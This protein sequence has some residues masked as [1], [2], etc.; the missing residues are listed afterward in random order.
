MEDLLAVVTMVTMLYVVTDRLFGAL[1]RRSQKIGIWAGLAASCALA[2]IRSYT[3]LVTKTA[4]EWAFYGF[5]GTTFFGLL[6]LIFMLVRTRFFSHLAQGEKKGTLDI[7]CCVSGGAL[8]GF[9]IYNRCRSVL[10][11]PFIFETTGKGFFSGEYFLR[12]AGWA[13][14]LLLLLLYACL[15]AKCLRGYRKLHLPYA[16]T[17][18]GV[19]LMVI[20]N[21]GRS[22]G[23]W[24]SPRG[25][26]K[27][28][29]FPVKYSAKLHRSWAVP[30]YQFAENGNFLLT[31]ILVGLAVLLMAA[32]FIQNTRIVDPYDNPAQKRKLRARARGYR[33][34]TA[35]VVVCAAL[36]VVSMTAVKAYASQVPPPPTQGEYTVEDGKLYI[37]VEDVNDGSLH[38]FKYGNVRW[39]VIKK[40]NGNSYGVGLDA[41]DVCGVDK[42]STYFQRG[43]QVVCRRCDVVMNVNTIGIYGGCN[44]VP[45]DYALS[46]GRLVFSLADIEAAESRFA[47]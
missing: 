36:A 40:P 18:I 20:R 2:V 24:A 47:K 1:G 31:M 4:S 14:A 32:L 17:M 35:G 41:C 22:V 23:T 11:Y 42:E 13:A 33:R 44:P 38:S 30:F 12:F 28:M 8:S 26:P 7:L 5:L 27:W 6:F 10:R 46:E 45:L 25:L 43:T 34:R 15:L 21:A 16:A 3:S 9:V 39:I 29:G 19:L 37:S